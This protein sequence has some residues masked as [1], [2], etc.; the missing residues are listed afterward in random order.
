MKIRKEDSIIKVF[1]DY[2]IDGEPFTEIV[3]ATGNGA[4][5]NCSIRHLNRK[6]LVAVLK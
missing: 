1:Q 5:I 4:K 2:E 6:V 3:K